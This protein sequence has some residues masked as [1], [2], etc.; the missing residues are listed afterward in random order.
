M[1]GNKK[2]YTEI[3]RFVFI[4]SISMIANTLI[5][6]FL[7]EF[8]GLNYLVSYFSCF[9]IVTACSFLMNRDWTFRVVSDNRMQESIRYFI[10]TFIAT[11][12]AMF[13]TWLLVT[14]EGIHYYYAVI[15]AAAVMTPTNFLMHRLFS[16]RLH[17]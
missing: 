16:F 6:I 1:K 11:I 12:I 14:K 3:V 8:L 5:I 13:I 2:I 9:A 15:I 17:Q 7:T 10:W 4:G